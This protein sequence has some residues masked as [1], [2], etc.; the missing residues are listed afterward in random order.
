MILKGIFCNTVSLVFVCVSSELCPRLWSTRP[1]KT[2]PPLSA[3][4][5]LPYPLSGVAPRG[6]L[7]D[8]AHEHVSQPQPHRPA[9]LSD[10]ESHPIIRVPRVACTCPSSVVS[11]RRIGKK[12][13]GDPQGAFHL[14]CFPFLLGNPSDP[15]T[16]HV[17][18]L[19][20]KAL[21]GRPP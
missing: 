3:S 16:D 9:F 15:K 10:A 20:C 8:V 13:S 6:A 14:P 1:Q 11:S 19:R 12:T 5:A 2:T 4:V 21:V 18:L 17:P 7:C